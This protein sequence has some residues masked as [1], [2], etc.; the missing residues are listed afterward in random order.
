MHLVLYK[1]IGIDI[2][3]R[4]PI[5]VIKE[6]DPVPTGFEEVDSIIDI[7]EYC[8]NLFARYKMVRDVIKGM[9]SDKADPE[10]VEAGF[11]LC[12]PEEK[13]V[14]AYHNIG[15]G[16][17]IAATITDL[18]DRDDSSIDYL[19][20]MKGIKTGVRDGRAVCLE[21]VVWSRLKKDS[22]Q[23]A[24]SVF[25]T[26]PEIIYSLITIDDP[27]H[28]VGEIGGNLLDLFANAGIGGL[29]DGDASLGILDFINST[30]TTRFEFLGLATHPALS[31]LVP[32][33]FLNMA[34]FALYLY[35]IIKFGL[36]ELGKTTL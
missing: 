23:V 24:P 11:D 8:F 28:A 9:V 14:A 19:D 3:K 6:S 22:I 18:S 4:P 30:P 7:N 31:T 2:D 1:K 12:T 34:E 21:A 25:V 17:Q 16:A 35:D 26:A 5:K 10:S 29:S 36:F 13:S 20:N 32:S 33:G 15:T 27:D